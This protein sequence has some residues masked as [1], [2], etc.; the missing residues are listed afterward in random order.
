M[1]KTSDLPIYILRK[2]F[3]FSKNFKS[4]MFKRILNSLL[5]GLLSSAVCAQN[6]VERLGTNINSEYSET[7]VII[8]PDGKSLYFSRKNHPQ[9]RGDENLEDIWVAYSRSATDWTM[10][11]NMGSPLNS[12]YQNAPIGISIN[13]NYLFMKGLYSDSANTILWQSQRE[14]ANRWHEPTPLSIPR[15]WTRKFSHS[16]QISADGNT[17]L[18]CNDGTLLVALRKG[19][20]SFSQP[21]TTGNEINPTDENGRPLTTI[22]AATLAADN[23]TLFFAARRNRD[24]KIRIYRSQRITETWQEWTNPEPLDLHYSLASDISLSL[25]LAAD[26]LYFTATDLETL[27]SDVFRVA[28][29]NETRPK[30]AA[31][32]KGQAQGKTTLKLKN[33]DNSQVK[34]IESQEDGKFIALLQDWQN[35]VISAVEQENAEG[36]AALT[37]SVYF[38]LGEKN[39]NEID[40]DH[41]QNVTEDNVALHTDNAKIEEL[42]LRLRGL[43]D[44]ISQVESVLAQQKMFEVPQEILAQTMQKVRPKTIAK[45]EQTEQNKPK[46]PSSGDANLDALRQKFRRNQAT[47]TPNNPTKTATEIPKYDIDKKIITPSSSTDNAEKEDKE[48]LALR[49]KMD[50]L[51]GKI[52]PPEQPHVVTPPPSVVT[53]KAQETAV[54]AAIASPLT[55]AILEG[56]WENL[57]YENML[58]QLND[59]RREVEKNLVNGEEKRL[60][61]T[62]VREKQRIWEESLKKVNAAPVQP[63]WREEAR[64]ILAEIIK[65]TNWKAQIKQQVELEL[66]IANKQLLQKK[67][68]NDLQQALKQA[69]R[70]REK[71]RQAT[72]EESQQAIYH[73]P[74]SANTEGLQSQNNE[75]TLRKILPQVGQKWVLN[76]VFFEVNTAYL[77]PISSDELDRVTYFLQKNPH[78]NIEISAHTNGKCS[79]DFAQKLTQSR[80]EMIANYLENNGIDI[81]RLKIK[82]AANTEPRTANDSPQ[83][84]RTN[85]RIEIKIIR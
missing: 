9:N 65:K 82:A 32:L 19:E 48:L 53:P 41:M 81:K 57:C 46:A 45:T 51:K 33:L 37:E 72:I 40:A 83:G 31:L 25:P 60:L 30:P 28:L 56:A 78:L 79:T 85:Q 68:Q 15:L 55:P 2:S 50:R 12:N 13:G 64:K 63:Q 44:E 6:F 62:A 59:V 47:N 14:N 24:E 39:W 29:P 22:F 76:G 73:T 36:S 70:N 10:A 1:M 54:A 3:V 26:W 8:A 34:I 5:I 75:I 4:Y 61:P 27:Q 17:L 69:E 18:V 80:A 7:N 42:R 71:R 77:R 20:G 43:D 67:W 11:A 52:P 84:L 38:H 49:K 23:K 16:Y 21:R 35:G 66:T 74:P 58:L